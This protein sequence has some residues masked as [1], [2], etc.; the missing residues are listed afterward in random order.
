VTWQALAP[1]AA[2]FGL[3]VP[4]ILLLYF[5]KVRRRQT[6][7]S[8]TLLWSKVVQ[9]RQANVP[10]QRLHASW[11]LLLQILAALALV[12]ALV[13]PAKPAPSAGARH[14]VV[15]VDTSV[16]MQSTDVEPSRFGV[17]IDM[18]RDLIANLG[19]HQ[20]M[21]LVELGAQPRI[22]G[23]STA[24]RAQ[25]LR[26]LETMRV[27][28]GR[29]DLQGALA[30]ASSVAG[31]AANARVVV[32]SDGITE[33]LG[34]PILLPFGVEYRRIGASAENLAITAVTVQNAGS[35]G[36]GNVHVANL[37]R[38]R[39]RTEVEWR[40]NG[41]LQDIKGVELAPGSG[42][43]VSFQLPPTAITAKASLTPRDLFQF[44]D[45]G[46]VVASPASAAK[47]VTVTQGNVFLEKAL[48][49]RPDL[50]VQVVAPKDFK[51][52][53]D[54]DLFVFDGFLPSKLPDKPFWLF[55]PPSGP[56]VRV[57]AP[58]AVGRLTA[59]R[60]DEPLLKDIDLSEVHVARSL[61]LT[62]ASF[63][64]NLVEADSFPVIQIR[65]QATPGVLF[66]FD[67]H[68]SDLPLRAAF[69]ILAD[70]LINQMLPGTGP[71][72]SYRPG[73]QVLTGATNRDTESKV[74][75][76]SGRSVILKP[77]LT[78][79]TQTGVPGLYTV[80]HRSSS[81][82]RRSYF[83]VNPFSAGE[84]SIAPKARLELRGTTSP[85]RGSEPRRFR[86]FWPWLAIAALILL[87]IEWNAFGG[88]KKLTGS[89]TPR[90]PANAL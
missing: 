79:F 70:R 44:D 13:R 37:G 3:V 30:L 38:Q 27:T 4:A 14:M 81:G 7:V 47:V 32:L 61:D 80:E 72:V 86:E 12:A 82:V 42:K 49:L 58:R 28:N 19:T 46:L 87:T 56:L 29:A 39:H 64:R 51:Q 68:E 57:G 9:D 35:G 31:R 2:G 63:G 67:L 45:A 43:D 48:S 54:A 23:A 50:N 15:M 33:P 6:Q 89:R 76:P 1:A 62:G 88:L 34:A 8:S 69:P 21:T 84:F 41:R 25:L 73:A 20:K 16:T 11:L 65:D 75:L 52:G 66:G 53:V 74:I 22:V 26:A 24:D 59:S 90:P 83:T 18:A 36:L 78:A 5:L 60:P 10:W 85:S 77:G 55:N 17:A 40:V 71:P